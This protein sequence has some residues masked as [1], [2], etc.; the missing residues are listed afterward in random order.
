M[1]KGSWVVIVAASDHYQAL[2]VFDEHYRLK[3][4][5][6]PNSVVAPYDIQEIPIPIGNGIIFSDLEGTHD[7]E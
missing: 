3:R 7:H 6:F 1:D 5:E 4:S 2:D